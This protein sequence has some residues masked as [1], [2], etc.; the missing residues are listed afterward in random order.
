MYAV[1][2]GNSFLDEE[3]C[4]DQQKF[5]FE[6]Q[7]CAV[8]AKGPCKPYEDCDFPQT[9]ANSISQATSNSSSTGTPSSGAVPP[10]SGA[11]PPSSGAVPPSSGAVPPSSGAVP[12]P[13]IIS[14]PTTVS[15]NSTPTTTP[16]PSTCNAANVNKRYSHESDCKRYYT[17]R[18]ITR[19]TYGYVNS[20]CIGKLVF[21]PT[22]KY[23][24]LPERVPTCKQ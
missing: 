1:C 22:Y 11:V 14:P 3:S 6:A 16:K 4:P 15:P 13:G 19:T 21:N 7:A 20:K 17:C 8:E 18:L 24:D 23:C 10:S 12:P 2:A 5:D 9:T